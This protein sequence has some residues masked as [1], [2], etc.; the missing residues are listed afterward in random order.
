MAVVFILFFKKRLVI[1]C[2][3]FLCRPPFFSNNELRKIRATVV[4]LSYELSTTVQQVCTIQISCCQFV[5]FTSLYFL[6]VCSIFKFSVLFLF[7]SD[8]FCMFYWRCRFVNLWRNGNFVESVSA[9]LCFL[10]YICVRHLNVIIMAFNSF[11]LSASVVFTNS[12]C[13]SITWHHWPEPLTFMF[14][15]SYP[16]VLV[17]SVPFLVCYGYANS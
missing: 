16:L 5:S 17:R 7:C 9:I 4:K 11:M 13:I 15:F 12:I 2:D 1:F 14:R 10:L 6:Y 8:H 3:V